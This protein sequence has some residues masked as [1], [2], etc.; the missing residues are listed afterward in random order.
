MYETIV[1]NISQVI[2]IDK[3]T[4][5][6]TINEYKEIKTD[7]HFSNPED[8]GEMWWFD[9]ISKNVVDNHVH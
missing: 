6:K 9:D 1:K 4:V 8:G 5:Y 7:S 3:S 2:G